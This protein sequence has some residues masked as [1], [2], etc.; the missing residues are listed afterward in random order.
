MRGRLNSKGMSAIVATLLIILLS[1]FAIGAFW[2][3]IKNLLVS[4]TDIL[5]TKQEFFSEN[6]GIKSVN[7]DGSKVSIS[8]GRSSGESIDKKDIKDIEV[9]VYV[10][11][12]IVSVV[13]LSGSMVVCRGITSTQC[14]NLGG[15]YSS[16]GGYCHTLS[17]DKKAACENLNGV[18]RD[19][20][21]PT[22]EANRQLLEML[23]EVEGTRIG[24]VAYN[25]SIIPRLSIDLTDNID[26]LNNTINSWEKA[27]GG[28]CICCGINDAVRMFNS[29]S[30]PATPKKMIVM[31]D[32]EA[33]TRCSSQKPGDASQDAINSACTAS[34][35][36]ANLTIYSIGF[37]EDANHETLIEIANCGDGEEFQA[38]EDIDLI[39]IY[40]HVSQEIITRSIVSDKINYIY[41][42][43]Y[44]QTSS[45]REVI[46]EIPPNLGIK[47]YS[48]NLAGKLEGE[49]IRIEVYPVILLKSGKEE[50]GPLFDSW[51]R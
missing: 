41:I 36:M 14:R 43:F 31:S 48:F 37:G 22:R 45:Y 1:M 47:A 44:T 24:L 29:F 16:A 19:R 27:I 10:P 38:L 8:L 21:S 4:Q 33:E 5:V 6:V 3:V 11:S 42:L 40:S 28:T 51:T 17:V 30:S 25:G 20:L 2:I 13:D 49:I 12:D 32:G 26:A 39:E 18:W 9:Q 46:Y 7:I 15:S 35:T 50:I 34:S 23:S